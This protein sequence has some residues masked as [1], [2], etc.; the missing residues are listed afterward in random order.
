MRKNRGIVRGVSLLLGGVIALTA[1]AGCARK[2]EDLE[3]QVA[4]DPAVS[5]IEETADGEYQVTLDD[6]TPPDDLADIAGRLND[7]TESVTDDDVVLRL[8]AGAWQW[9]LSGDA[10]ERAD[11]A[12]A[13][14]ELVGVDG[15]LQGRVWSSEDALGI[16]AVAEAGVEPVSVVMPLADAAAAGPLTGGLQL[17]VSDVHER[18]TVETRNPEK[19]KPA[20]EAVVEVAALAPI[21]RYSLDDESLSLRMRSVEGAAA[22]TP[23]V[24][25]LN[26]GDSGVGVSLISG[27][28]SAPAAQQDLA[29]RLSAI[30]TPI[31][32]VIGASIDTH[33]PAA[34]H[35]SV[36]TTDAESAATVQQALLATPD[37]QAFNSLQLF[38][39]KQDEPGTWATG[40]TMKE[41]GFVENFERALS[42]AGTEGVR[43]AAIGPLE[44]DVVLE[45]GADAAAVAPAIKAAA[46]R[47]QEAEIFGSTSWGPEK[48]R[49]LYSFDV[50]GKLHVNLVN[51]YGD[52]D[53][54]VEAW[55][56]APD[57]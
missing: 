57:L 19:V 11:L 54:F 43:S 15:I 1:L 40:K 16:E 45:H 8:R 53:A 55:N 13:V 49:A 38:V 10:G 56:D 4:K 27:I 17:K 9:T 21:Q 36:T 48:D 3:E 35:L 26:A 46:L 44:L 24:D 37:L 29:A 25:A 51:G 47:D 32:G 23:V 50:T 7:L 28:I 41:R 52:E 42:L 2:S 18:S 12:Q 20:L 39:L 34:L 22:A 5:S 6:S 30:L 14:S 31:D 33:G